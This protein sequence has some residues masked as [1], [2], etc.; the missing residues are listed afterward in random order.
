MTEHSG[1][2]EWLYLMSPVHLSGGQFCDVI[3]GIVPG[4]VVSE[5]A[6]SSF[7]ANY[8]LFCLSQYL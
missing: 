2:R 7:P 5:S 6:F 1:S 3:L 4:C 8:F